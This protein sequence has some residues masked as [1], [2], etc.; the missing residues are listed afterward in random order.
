MAELQPGF[1]I[2]SEIQVYLGNRNLA[3]GLVN[4]IALSW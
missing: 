4:T 3:F 1:S 2:E